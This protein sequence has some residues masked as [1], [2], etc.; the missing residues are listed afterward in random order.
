MQYNTMAAA[1][2]AAPFPAASVSSPIRHQ[3]HSVESSISNSYLG[4]NDSYH[5]FN[6]PN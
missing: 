1:N 3:V 4:G 5:D 6:T 2:F